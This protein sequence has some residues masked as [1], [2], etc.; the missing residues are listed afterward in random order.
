MFLSLSFF[1]T[2]RWL[3][4]FFQ[5]F[6]KAVPFAASGCRCRTVSVSFSSALTGF[7]V[8]CKNQWVVQ[9]L[10]HRLAVHTAP[11]HLNNHT[12]F[13]RYSYIYWR[14]RL[15]VVQHLMTFS[16]HEKSAFS[17]FLFL[18]TTFDVYDFVLED[19]LQ[20]QIISNF[21]ALTF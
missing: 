14:C 12:H 11:K 3:T 5:A 15:K 9:L 7:W 1:M 4:N 8:Q 17:L 10:G 16:S 2:W 20:I 6:F 19:I 13:L 21:H 18:K